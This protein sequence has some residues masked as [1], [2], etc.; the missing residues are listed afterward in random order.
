MTNEEKVNQVQETAFI[1]SH[2]ICKN[3][4]DAQDI[5]QDVCLQYLL[6]M[7]DPDNPIRNPI[8]WSKVVAR[9]ATYKKLKEQNKLSV[10]KNLDTLADINLLNAVVVEKS[11]RL[12]ELP[13]LEIEEVK[14]L[15]N[16]DDFET[17][18][19]F[20]EHKGKSR[21]YAEANKLKY[22]AATTKVYRMKRNLKAAYLKEAGYC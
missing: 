3:Y 22:S 20:L 19:S 15:L 21:N 16:K 17:Y 14:E 18:A 11:E 6:K 7:D 4:H 5:A 9:N 12:S 10:N 13:D 8:S 1:T 2:Y